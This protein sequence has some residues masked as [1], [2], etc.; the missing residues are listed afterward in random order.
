M[1]H[2]VWESSIKMADLVATGVIPVE[3]RHVLE[4]GAGAGLPSI[5]SVLSGAKHVIATDYPEPSVIAE[6]KRNMDDNLVSSDEQRRK[7][8]QVMGHSWGTTDCGDLPA[9]FPSRRVDVILAADTLW[10]HDQH[11]NLFVRNLCLFC[12]ILFTLLNDL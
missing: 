3:N 2:F 9:Q 7:C 11:D 8:V 6:L 5:V 4:V 12:P 10:L 1:A